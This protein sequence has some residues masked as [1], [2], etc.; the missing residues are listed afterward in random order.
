MRVLRIVGGLD[1]A[2]GG[3]SES[4]VNQCVAA[5]QAGVDNTLAYPFHP[6]VAPAS[7]GTLDTLR[8]AGVILRGFPFSRIA[9]Q[10]S[11]RWAVS[12]RLS[13]WTLRVLR[14]Y[15]VIHLHSAWGA[16]QLVAL[17]AATRLGRPCVMTPHE[18]LTRFDIATS[19]SVPPQLKRLIRREYMARLSLV[20]FSSTLEANDSMT[21][22]ARARAV[23]IPHP[24]NSVLS[25]PPARR[26]GRDRLCHWVSGPAAPKEEHRVANSRSVTCAGGARQDCG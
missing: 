10:Q 3:P 24:V 19:G 18:S 14:Q 16:A 15:D 17:E 13:A 8:S 1:P 9:L 23:V 26:T 20:V 5:Q 7:E 25:S 2:F 12:P 6:E 4:A 11:R 22:R 21:G